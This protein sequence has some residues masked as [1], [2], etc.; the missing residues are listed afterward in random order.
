MKDPVRVSLFLPV[1][2]SEMTAR[3]DNVEAV[4]EKRALDY[5]GPRHFWPYRRCRPD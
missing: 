2:E 1:Q 5:S 3:E 4:A